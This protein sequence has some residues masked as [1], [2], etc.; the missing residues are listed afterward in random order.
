MKCCVIQPIYSTDYSRMGELFDREMALL[1]SCK[2]GCDIIVLP[3]SSNIPAM[4]PGKDEHL[5][6]VL[7]YGPVLFEKCADAARRCN[8]LGHRKQT[9]CQ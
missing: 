3:E 4:C 7:K 5:E 2:P 1:D 9:Q 8:S 6:T